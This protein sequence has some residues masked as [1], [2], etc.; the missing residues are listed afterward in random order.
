MAYGVKYRFPFESVEGVDWTID[1]LKD[2]YSGAV[3]IRPVGGSPQLRKDKNDNICGTSLDLTAEC[4]TDGEFEEFSSSNPFS[5]QVKVYRGST[6]VWQGYVSPELYNAPD[7]AP[8][9][10]VRVTATD[11]LGELKLHFFEAQGR[12]S[13]S[14]LLTYLLGFTGLSLGFRQISDLSCSASGVAGML[15]SVYVDIDFLAGETCYDVLQ[16][17]LGAIHST[18]TQDGSYWLIQKETGMSI[19][20]SAVSCYVNGVSSQRAI[21]HFGSMTT[22]SSSCW[23]VGHMTREYVAPKK[24]MIVTADNHY[25]TNILGSWTLDGS[26]TDEGDYWDLPAAGDGIS[27]TITFQQEVSK[28]LVLSIKVRNVGEGE[29]AGNLGVF[30]QLDGSY[31]QSASHLYLSK[32]TGK[33]RRTGNDAVW[34]TVSSSWDAEVQAPSEADTDQDYVTIDLVIPLYNNGARSYVRASSLNIQIFNG[35]QLYSKRVYGV[36]LYQYEQTKGFKKIVNIDNGAR[37]ESP[38]LDVIFPCTTDL[39]NYN[40]AEELLFAM[41][42]NSSAAK[43]TSWSTQAFSSLDYL[44]L[45]AR[46]YAL[47]IAT[48]RVRVSGVLQTPAS[49]LAIPVIFVDDHDSVKYIVESFSWDLYNDE[50]SVQMISLP[51]SSITVDGAETMEGETENP[52]DH[53]QADSSVSGGGGG[54]E[55]VLPA[56]TSGA[57][58]GIKIGYT[59]NAKN[60]PVQ[61]DSSNKAYVSVPW[62]GGSGGGGGTVTSVGLSM[63]TPFSVSGSPVSSSGTIDVSL[64]STY[65]I[66]TT[67]EWNTLDD[68]SHTH[69]NKSVLDGITSQKVSQWDSATGADTVDVSIAGTNAA[70]T[71]KVAL[72][73]GSNDSEALP[74]ASSSKSGLVS[75]GAQTFAG[76]KT[77]TRIY[78]GNSEAYGMYIEW[79]DTNH[80]FKI[81]G[82]V[83]AT[84]DVAA[85]G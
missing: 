5:F 36:S 61:L 19:G 72:G 8:P 33:R 80:M 15:S 16:Y 46:D 24:K 82:D 55:Y 58:G 81:V 37:G 7:I 20:S 25:R 44:S 64:K 76:N 28:H 1:I 43:I 23:P 53:Q 54:G 31:Y 2:G 13:I 45:I 30:V 85:G 3:N 49:G 62:E 14:A 21:E 67:S 75:T 50:V 59:Q 48:P 71:V 39:N 56:A 52:L 26:A 84:G 27:Q 66:P 79:D 73:S 9:Y 18:I 42:V 69:S 70:P 40:G 83:Y 17:L 57:L 51:A 77:F 11:G 35:D 6:L 47:S 38:D 32:Y 10:D 12:K 34:S 78:L 41:P 22:H 68:A 65:K 29:D 74:I 60:Y 4:H 63:P